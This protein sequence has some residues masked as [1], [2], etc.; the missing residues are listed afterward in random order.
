MGEK[1][2][3]IFKRRI[4]N[5]KGLWNP[6]CYDCVSARIFD[7]AGADLI[8]VSGYGISM[9]LLGLPD[10]GFVSLPE[11]SMVTSHVVNCVDAP[12]I[13]D[14]D[15]G[16][17]N[18]LNVLRTTREIIGTGAAA[19]LLED[20]LAPKRCGHMAGKQVIP[21]AEALG[22]YKA[23]V[24]VRNEL[25][26]DF[27]IVARTDA[28]GA[29]GGS[30]EEAIDRAN[31]YLDVGADVAFVEG[32]ISEEEIAVTV[33]RVKGPIVYN[34]IGISPIIP[35]PR[36]IEIGVSIIG[37]G[38]AQWAATKAMW[39]YAHDLKKRGMEAQME[40]VRS[41]QGHPLEEFHDFAGFPQMKKLEE[42]Y[43]PKEE[44]DEKYRD[45]LG[46]KPL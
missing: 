6:L 38:N 25:D 37:F 30:L 40:Y 31:A 3:T 44:V 45:T 35:V 32:L 24:D 4:R 21:V 11:L 9:S 15:T 16:F 7:K 34:M 28:R 10:M 2:S 39:D 33:Q 41:V 43:L 27:V 12:V 22:K 18:A 46:Y 36:L 14:A 29:V 20:Q 1:K 23:A 42:K 26:P 8:A 17:G 5:E 13:A 19:M